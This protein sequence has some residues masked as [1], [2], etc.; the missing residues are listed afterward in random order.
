MKRVTVDRVRASCNLS[1]LLQE[2]LTAFGPDEVGIS[3]GSSVDTFIVIEVPDG[4]TAEAV[5]LVVLAH[6]PDVQTPT[7]VLYADMLVSRQNVLERGQ[8]ALD[9]LE[10]HLAGWSAYTTGQKVDAVEDMMQIVHDTV[11]FLLRRVQMGDL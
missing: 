7:E 5:A 2:L 1:G 8:A 6:D 10:T 4:V 9:Q 11:K 3:S